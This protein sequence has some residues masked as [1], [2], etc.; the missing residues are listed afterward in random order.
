MTKQ[1]S[2]SF[3]LHQ[4]KSMHTTVVPT[5]VQ[6]KKKVLADEPIF[7]LAS[8]DLVEVDEPTFNIGQHLP[9]IRSVLQATYHQVPIN[10]QCS[11]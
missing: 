3:S 6:D 2:W 10:S 4:A 8:V 1:H 7:A 9:A 5:H 11:P